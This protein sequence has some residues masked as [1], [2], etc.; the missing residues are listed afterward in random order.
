MSA[1]LRARSRRILRAQSVRRPAAATR[2]VDEGVEIAR[3]FAV[4]DDK[5]HAADGL[6]VVR[7]PEVPE[8][9]DGVTDCPG[10]SREREPCAWKSVLKRVAE[11]F[12][13]GVPDELAVGIVEVRTFIEVGFG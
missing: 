12:Q 9:A 2:L 10:S 4:Y 1:D 3:L 8:G 6:R 11:G 5:V 13:P 7:R